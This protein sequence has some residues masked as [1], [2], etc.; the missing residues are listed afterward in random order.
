[1]I[2]S[3]VVIFFCDGGTE[4]AYAGHIRPDNIVMMTM[5]AKHELEWDD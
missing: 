5:K 4:S 2:G 3:E 1:M